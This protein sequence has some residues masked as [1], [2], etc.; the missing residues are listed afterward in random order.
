M[1]LPMPFQMLLLAIAG[2]LNQEQRAEIEFLQE[3]LRVF[4]ELTKGRRL[5]LNDDQRCRLA[6]KGKRLG[7][8]KLREIV[9]IVPPDTI[10]RWHRKPTGGKRESSAWCH[11]N[12]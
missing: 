12:E 5:R 8:S 4:K 6:A 10:L 7:R 2:W 9:T 11:R 3:Q 1:M